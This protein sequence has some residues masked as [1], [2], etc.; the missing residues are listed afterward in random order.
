MDAITRAKLEVAAVDF[1]PLTGS[2]IRYIELSDG[3]NEREAQLIN[4]WVQAF[5]R[6]HGYLPDRYALQEYM[7][8]LDDIG[9]RSYSY[10]RR[11]MQVSGNSPNPLKADQIAQEPEPEPERKDPAQLLRDAKT[12]IDQALVEIQ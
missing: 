8:Q 4:R 9:P 11:T 3:V 1:D 10:N 12:L 5:E 2:G 6:T 7:R